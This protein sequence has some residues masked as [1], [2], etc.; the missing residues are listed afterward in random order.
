VGRHRA[1]AAARPTPAPGVTGTAFRRLLVAWGVSVLGDGVR[2]VAL[3]LVAALMTGS[4]LAVTAVAAAELVPWLLFS[5]PSG[6]LVD[7]W[8]ARTALLV[9]HL[10]RAALSGVLVV[11]LLHSSSTVALLCAL[12]FLLTVAETFADAASQVLLVATAGPEDLVPANARVRTVESLTLHLA[13]PLLGGVLVAVQPALAFAVDGLTFVVAAA[14]VTTLPPALVPADAGGPAEPLL[15]AV[16]EGVRAV[17]AD[18]GLRLVVSVMAWTSLA[19]G[20]V[21]AITT[22]YALQVLDLP[23]AL[24]PFVLVLQAVGLLLGSRL[25]TPT[26]SRWGEGAVMTLALVLVGGAYVVIGLVPRVPVVLTCYLVTGIGFA[27]WNVLA[28]VRRQ[29]LTPEGLLGR[30]S[31]ASR[32]ATWGA[33]PLGALV[34]GLLATATSLAVVHVAAG[35]LVLVVAGLTR[36][37]LRAAP[38]PGSPLRQPAPA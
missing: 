25:V 35:V 23:I 26:V 21:E 11:A 20:A 38:R 28:S 19:T 29:R 31:N 36:A 14:L 10:V 24:V 33:M 8:D 1:A 3:P 22:L 34:A 15:Q 18:R 5:L 6:A 32:A 16:R 27:L 2:M 4:P 30:V 12:A 37:A 17:L 7:R 13:G 9:S